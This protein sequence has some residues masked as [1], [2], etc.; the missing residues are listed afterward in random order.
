MPTGGGPGRD[1]SAQEGADRMWDEMLQEVRVCQT[2]AQILFGFLLSVAF[3]P[4]FAE[5]GGFDKGL[6]V[7]T[8][9]LGACATGA[10]IAPVCLH[11]VLTGHDVKPALVR[12]GGVFIAVGLSLL[13]LVIAT[14]LL[15]LL[16]T[17]TDNPALAAVLSVLVL[18][19]FGVCRVP[20]RRPRDRSGL[21]VHAEFSPGLFGGVGAQQGVDLE[22]A[23][24]G[25]AQEVFVVELFED[26]PGASRRQVAHRRDDLRA[27]VAFGQ[28]A[29]QAVDPACFV[30]QGSVGPVEGRAQCPAAGPDPE[31]TGLVEVIGEVD[32]LPR[33]PGV[34]LGRRQGHGER[35]PTAGLDDFPGRCRRGL[36]PVATG[37]PR[38]EFESLVVAELG[39][40]VWTHAV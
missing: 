4:R 35:Q 3:M 12:V 40:L 25:L 5:L 38:Q 26:L 13:A 22:A 30:G 32:H 31:R 34:E 6:Y 27:R 17:A 19:W 36:D 9:V 1:E 24:D 11:R 7:V 2:G 8:V 20:G 21:V 37:D 14:A 23:R 15:L 33:R 16:R 10:L 39:Q 18:G 29:P 28:D